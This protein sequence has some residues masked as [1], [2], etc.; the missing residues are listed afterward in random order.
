LIVAF[1]RE[2]ALSTVHGRWHLRV[3]SVL[4]YRLKWRIS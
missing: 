1:G 3:K 2:D 4:K